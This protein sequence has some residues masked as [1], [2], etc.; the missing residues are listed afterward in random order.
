[1]IKTISII[2]TDNSEKTRL[3]KDLANYFS[4]N[5]VVD[6]EDLVWK[7]IG[8]KTILKNYFEI[9]KSRKSLKNWLSTK[10]KIYLFLDTCDLHTIWRIKTMFPKSNSYKKILDNLEKSDLYI[11][12]KSDEI[13]D[14]LIG[15]L[16]INFITLSGDYESIRKKSIK[17]IEKLK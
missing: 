1:M 8:K 13:L 10:A 4:T 5:F 14:K 15:D 12:T 2:G 11:I 3:T 7:S 17:E 16:E 9:I 6:Y